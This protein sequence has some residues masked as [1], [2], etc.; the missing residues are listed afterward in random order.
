MKVHRY[1]HTTPEKKK[2]EKYFLDGTL[3]F[4]SFVSSKNFNNFSDLKM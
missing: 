1:V 4:R 2:Y 3:V